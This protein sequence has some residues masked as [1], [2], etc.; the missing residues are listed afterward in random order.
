[1]PLTLQMGA[2]EILRIPLRHCQS[3][4]AD[5]IPNPAYRERTYQSNEAYPSEL[6]WIVYRLFQSDREKTTFL[7]VVVDLSKREGRS[8]DHQREAATQENLD[9]F[10][11]DR[12]SPSAD[13]P[14]QV[15]SI[16]PFRYRVN[17]GLHVEIR[18]AV[19]LSVQSGDFVFALGKIVRSNATSSLL[20][21]KIYG[22]GIDDE[23]L[24]DQLILTCPMANPMWIRSTQ[25]TKP[26]V[27]DKAILV[28][29]LFR[30]P[31]NFS[32]DGK[33]FISTPGSWFDLKTEGPKRRGKRTRFHLGEQ[34]LI[35]WS[36]VKLFDW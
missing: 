4:D 9:K 36:V 5:P 22:Y 17:A 35:G 8:E 24:F 34:H 31:L 21:N 2:A 3:F 29:E 26:Y 10:V 20:E 7:R 15:K 19:G 13:I 18:N 33:V 14:M 28:V 27:D 32:T 12:L 30:I 1:M 16:L 23:L 11:L 25:V 6:E